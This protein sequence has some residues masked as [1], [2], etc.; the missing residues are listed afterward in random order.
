MN[1]PSAIRKMG[2][3]LRVEFCSENAEKALLPCFR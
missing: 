1:M 3:G 2:L